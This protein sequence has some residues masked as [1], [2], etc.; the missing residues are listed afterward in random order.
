MRS[1]THTKTHTHVCV[2]G[3]YHLSWPLKCSAAGTNLHTHTHTYLTVACL[4]GNNQ[5]H[6]AS[7]IQC[8]HCDELLSRFSHMEFYGLW[9]WRCRSK[10]LN[11][12]FPSHIKTLSLILSAQTASTTR[13]PPGETHGN[14]WAEVIPRLPLSITEK[15]MKGGTR[16]A[17]GR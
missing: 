5:T 8:I 3:N 16:K 2:R 12:K 1:T 11:I 15:W 17:L 7:I 13:R 6:A 14:N 9:M 10:H 4:I